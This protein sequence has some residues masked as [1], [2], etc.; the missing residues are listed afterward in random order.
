M[1]RISDV[2]CS[3][4]HCDRPNRKRGWCEM[5]YK[6]WRRYG[7]PTVCQIIRGD[8]EARFWSH[9]DVRGPDECW[10]WTGR[11]HDNGYGTVRWNG[12]TDSPH[13]ASYMIANGSI[14]DDTVVDHTCHNGD[15]L[16]PSGKDC[17]HRRC[18]N[19]AHLEAVPFQT[20]VL[21][22]NGRAAQ[23]ARK[24]GCPQGHPYDEANTVVYRGGRYCR[25]CQRAPV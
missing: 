5:H 10:P 2:P 6:R 11:I 25:A 12:K 3:V 17:L 1:R 20:N 14:P 21:R 22:G 24:T 8:D 13:R 19:P 9:V 15:P 4:E 23:N 18:T 7:D 16:C